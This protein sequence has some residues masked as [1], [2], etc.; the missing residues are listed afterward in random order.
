M[1]PFE[2]FERR[3]VWRTISM[4]I[5]GMILLAMAYQWLGPTLGW[6]VLLPLWLGTS[7]YAASRLRQRHEAVAAYKERVGYKD[8]PQSA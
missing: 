1:T 6:V 8:P 5:G 7:W 4:F 3:L 2:K